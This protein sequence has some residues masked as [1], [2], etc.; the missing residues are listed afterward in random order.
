MGGMGKVEEFVPRPLLDRMAKG[1]EYVRRARK[2][3]VI[4]HYDA[5]GC[6]SAAILTKALLRE[7]KDL[8][9][10]LAHGLAGDLVERV[11]EGGA[12]VL[13]VSDIGSGQ[14]D[15]LEAARM[16]VVVLDHHQPLRETQ[17][18]TIVHANPH[19]FGISGTKGACG[20][21]T[22]FL[23]SIL[24]NEANWE[25]AG[26]AL[27]GCIGD[28]QHVGGFKGINKGLM[29]T[30]VE[31][32]FLQPERQL[33]LKDLPIGEALAAATGPYFRGLSGEP[34]GAT[35]LLKALGID[36]ATPLRSLQGAQLEALTSYLALK[37][38][39][40]GC[41]PETVLS[42]REEKHWIS[43]MGLFADELETFINAAARLN[44]EPLAVAMALGDPQALAQG[45]ELR[46]KY[47]EE[48]LRGLKKLDQDGIPQGKH[49]QYFY[50]ENPVLA[51]S[52]CG[53][54][55]QY[56]FN[57]EKPTLC[58]APGEA[59]TKISSRATDYLISKGVDLAAALREAS[60]AVGGN[61]GGHNIAAGATIP[62]GTEEKFIAL[63]DDI[64]GRQVAGQPIAG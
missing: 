13:V 62:K 61:G 34:A 3:R 44:K 4:S 6:T 56:L 46:E 50:A 31:K 5:D 55:M 28:R 42:L 35:R 63:V 27:A 11:N 36:P 29:A 16:P 1:R 24:L 7:G 38:V 12:D 10:T 40:Q 9:I 48:I 59:K 39:Q 57:Q 47:T 58:L 23:F 22:T 18:E 15:A 32:G 51:G 14:I 30:A 25:L 60:A 26:I 19:L 21:T 64:V 52:W 45:K 43:S 37:L 8:Q 20:A 41:R 17:R 49:I 53:L 33:A 2:V 54:G